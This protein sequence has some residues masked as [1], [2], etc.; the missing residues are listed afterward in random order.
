VTEWLHSNGQVISWLALVALAFDIARNRRR[1][2]RMMRH[3]HRVYAGILGFTLLGCVYG[4]VGISYALSGLGPVPFPG[5]WHGLF[6]YVSI[7]TL[8]SV[9]AVLM[10]SQPVRPQTNRPR[11]I[12]AIGAHP[13]DI[14]I[15]CG[16]A[17]AR[18]H[19]EGHLVEGLILTLGSRGGDGATRRLEA[20]NGAH[21]LGLTALTLMDMPDTCLEA[22]AV[23]QAIEDKIQSFQPDV[24]FT[25]SAHDRHQDH[26]IVHRA[27]LQAARRVNTILCYESPS[28]TLDFRPELFIEIGDYVDVKVES[29]REH[30]NQAGKPYVDSALVRAQALVRGEQARTRYAEGFEIQRALVMSGGML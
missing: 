17:L 14:E 24:I 10:R 5:G 1:L 9:V 2:R 26:Q 6:P 15:A 19:D 7:L 3:G 13:D 16:G 22:D 27:T 28:T 12:L 29:I 21:F 4:A 11:R 25:H 20:V 18:L 30:R 8:V 23:R